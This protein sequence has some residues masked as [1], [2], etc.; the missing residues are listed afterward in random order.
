MQPHNDWRDI[1]EVT[2]LSA[3][4]VAALPEMGMVEWR[5]EVFAVGQG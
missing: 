3:E 5:D 4:T 1:T 2:D